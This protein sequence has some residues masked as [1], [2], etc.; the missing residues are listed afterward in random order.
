MVNGTTDE[1]QFKLL[2][3]DESINSRKLIDTL[4]VALVYAAIDIGVVILL[5]SGLGFLGLGAEPSSP[6][7]GRMVSIGVD[8]F[9]QWWMWLFP[10]LAIA[11]FVI[12][13]SFIGAGLRAASA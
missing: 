8:F 5:F 1:V 9:D 13:V 10:G 4:A 2:F 3:P 6:E 12:A 7:W 11:T